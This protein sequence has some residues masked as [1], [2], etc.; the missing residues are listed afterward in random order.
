[1]HVQPYV[2][3]ECSCQAAVSV[4]PLLNPLSGSM[5]GYLE[6]HKNLVSASFNARFHQGIPLAWDNAVAPN[7]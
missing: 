1:M 5:L 4:D 3:T 2:P 6:P 7:I